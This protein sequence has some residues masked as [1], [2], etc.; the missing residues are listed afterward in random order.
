MIHK[1]ENQLTHNFFS[2]KSPAR[3]VVCIRV[4]FDFSGKR[5]FVRN[6]DK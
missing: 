6:H 3:K 1:G 5:V 2:I 4:V